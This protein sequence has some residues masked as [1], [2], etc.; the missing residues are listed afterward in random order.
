MAVFTPV[1]ICN[2]AL[3]HVGLGQQIAS[4]DDVGAIAQVCRDWYAR[5]RDEVLESF[6]WPVTRL[7]VSPGLVEA[8][9]NDDWANSF[10]YPPNALS[11]I[12]V[13]GGGLPQSEAIPFDVGQDATGKLI[14]CDEDDIIVEIVALFED[15][16]E[17]KATFAKA[18]SW[19]MAR[20]IAGPLRR[21]SQYGDRAVQMYAQELAKA[22]GIAA[23]EQ[24]KKPRP[25]SSYVSSR[26]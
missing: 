2:M 23:R 11:L 7:Q 13:V 17:W 6:E 12:R 20:D 19:A 1:D 5:A 4:L 26:Y 14:Y 15:T 16:G 10:R 8:E 21:P 18:T 25:P 22:E 3:G 9:P 24:A